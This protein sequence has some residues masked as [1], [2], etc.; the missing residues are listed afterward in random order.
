MTAISQLHFA[1]R[2]YGRFR[3]SLL[4]AVEVCGSIGYIRGHGFILSVYRDWFFMPQGDVSGMFLNLMTLRS[5]LA[6]ERFDD[7]HLNG[8]KTERE[9]SCRKRGSLLHTIL[10]HDSSDAIP[11][12]PEAPFCDEVYERN[13]L[14]LL[15]I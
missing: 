6:G 3:I 15:T 14:Y 11:H 13:G 9:K 1:C 10:G 12:E 7:W 8:K 2:L 5:A 4:L